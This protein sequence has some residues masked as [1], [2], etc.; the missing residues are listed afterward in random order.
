MFVCL[1]VSKI[2]EKLD[3][4]SRIF[5]WPQ[6]AINKNWLDFRHILL[7]YLRFRVTATWLEVCTLQVL[8]F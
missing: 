2:T 7:M 1:S 6:Y 8:L 3:K 4:F 5:R